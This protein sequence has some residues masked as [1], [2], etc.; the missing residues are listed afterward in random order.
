MITQFRPSLFA[1][2]QVFMARNPDSA[3]KLGQARGS[4]IVAAVNA[5]LPVAEYSRITSYN[6]CYTKLLRILFLL[7]LQHAHLH[8]QLVAAV[9]LG[10]LQT[11][12]ASLQFGLHLIEGDGGIA[13]KQ[14]SGE[15]Q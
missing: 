10:L 3:L 15:D 14:R 13:G 11:T 7:G 9:L 1:I 2:E 12:L 4:A 6:V 8:G 5:G